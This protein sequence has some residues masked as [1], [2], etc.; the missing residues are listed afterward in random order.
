MSVRNGVDASIAVSAIKYGGIQDVPDAPTIGTASTS[1]AQQAS[2]AF[3]PSTKGGTPTTYRVISN[4]G[5][6]EAT[7]SS[8]PI[9]ITDLNG[10][11]AYTFTVK[12][13][14]STG[15]STSSAS[16]SV[17]PTTSHWISIS[18]PEIY[19]GYLGLDSS[20]NLYVLAQDYS[21]VYLG[22]PEVSLLTKFS[23]AGNTKRQQIIRLPLDAGTSAVKTDSS[24]NIYVAGNSPIGSG[25]YGVLL[26]FN[27][28][29][30]Y[31]WGRKLQNTSISNSTLY[32]GSLGFDSTGSVYLTGYVDGTGATATDA[33]LAKY[34]SSGTLQWQRSLTDGDARD[35]VIDGSDNI[36]ICGSANANGGLVAK[37]NSSGTLQW[38]K[39][40]SVGIFSR[41]SVDSSGNVY[42]AGSK[43]TVGTGLGEVV[44]AK[45]NSSGTLQWQRSFGDTSSNR[46][47]R[48]I[49]VDSSSNV[50]VL[51][52]SDISAIVLKYNSSGVLQWQRS[53]VTSPSPSSFF[54]NDLVVSS[55]GNIYI[56][57]YDT[58]NVIAKLPSDGTK[59][60]T[61]TVLGTSYIY[62]SSS[63]SESAGAHTDSTPTL[64]SVTST[65]TDSE[66]T[67]WVVDANKAYTKTTF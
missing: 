9:T 33:F 23:S 38:Q 66:L 34:N 21:E 57:W 29:G 13:E 48:G 64:T 61:Y 59:T 50:Y 40:L 11:T 36:Y 42:V 56:S 20:E 46:A 67:S 10:G 53:I 7:G 43:Y 17:T 37:Y 44:T 3:T 14:N 62:A 58:N 47:A 39:K 60:G 31:Q 2:V 65:Y 16:N 12:A 41:V 28:S 5:S 26:K 25:Y 49:D 51:G 52:Y 54:G 24:G 63:I 22:F 18:P 32:P 6:I 8:S 1:T 45:Y 55:G 35:I 19:Y 15:S 30:A 27:S 4:P